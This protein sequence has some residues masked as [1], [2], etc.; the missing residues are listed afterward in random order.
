M[1]VHTCRTFR[2]VAFNNPLEEVGVYLEL[3]YGI[4]HSIALFLNQ[5]CNEMEF[6]P[7]CVNPFLV[8]NGIA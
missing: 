8:T 3:Y 1:I 2:N 7:W 5:Y 4:I 6:V